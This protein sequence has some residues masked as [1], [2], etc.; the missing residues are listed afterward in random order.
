ML[1]VHRSTISRD[2][3]RVHRR[4]LLGPKA[5]E[6]ARTGASLDR[7]AQAEDAAE[8]EYEQNK[9]EAAEMLSEC[10]APDVS[11]QRPHSHP[12]QVPMW[13][14]ASRGSLASRVSRVLPGARASGRTGRR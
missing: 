4:M 8:V 2:V 10:V 14:P 3:A 5:D 6:M 12:V 9:I 7:I 11:V 1:G 13:L